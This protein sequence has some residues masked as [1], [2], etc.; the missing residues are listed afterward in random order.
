MDR[1]MIVVLL[2]TAAL[3][4]RAGLAL[5]AIGL[6][7]SKNAASAVMRQ[8]CDFFVA[9]LAL[10]L[11][12]AAI[13]YFRVT[14]DPPDANA[15][16]IFFYAVLFSLAPGVVAGVLG[17][18][19]RFLPMLMV[20]LVLCGAVIPLL[21]RWA[22]HG[23][24]GE[25]KF[26]DAAGAS[27]VHLSAAA[28]ALAGAIVVGPRAGKYNRDG[29]S[30]AI[31]GHNLSVA[32][33]GALLL[34]VGWLPLVLDGT[35]LHGV[36]SPRVAS[37]VLLAGSA[38]GLVALLYGRLRYGKPE[39]LITV[40]G[41]LGGLV[42]ISAAA[43]V[44]G[45]VGAVAIGSV[46]GIL[47]PLAAVAIDLRAHIDDPISGI[48]IHGVGGLWGTLAAGMLI[49]VGGLADKFRALGV[50]ALGAVVVAGFS[51]I[52]SF[53]LFYLLRA[54]VGIRS[55]E[56]DEFDGLDLAEHDIN[57]YPDFQQTMIKS[58]HLREA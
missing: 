36:M 2:G 56:A 43:G 24:L 29:S 21:A 58:Y 33:A 18:R 31:P 26:I 5:Y 9:V 41:F 34:L 8:L 46:A 19:S 13:V 11:I 57:A 23:W 42:S 32:A 27:V 15:D 49:S 50:Q 7:R 14:P 12:G 47:V 28:C 38:G 30:N 6:S 1:W 25:M 52:A 44:V 37:N 39:I 54:A 45:S 35:A 48:A 20:P 10:Y 53:A 51:V 17:E 22:W 55:K 3:L 16:A 4:A 40:S